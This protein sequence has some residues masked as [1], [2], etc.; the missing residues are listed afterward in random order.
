MS[1]QNKQCFSKNKTHRNKDYIKR[2]LQ[3]DYS[4][5]YELPPHIEEAVEL[6]KKIQSSKESEK[7]EGEK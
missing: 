2:S 4:F 5:F 3:Q 7:Q 1:Y 6:I